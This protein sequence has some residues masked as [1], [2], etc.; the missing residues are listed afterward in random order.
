M[1]PKLAFALLLVCIFAWS[2]SLCAQVSFFQPPTFSGGGN[3][4]VADF[5]GDGKPDILTSDGTMNVGNGDG[6]FTL[7]TSI[8]SSPV[9]VLAV[10]DF[11]GDG[12]ADVLEQGTGTLLV[13][14]GK[15]DGTFQA[16][17]STASGAS[18][19]GVIV[20]DVN[21][22]GKPDVLGVFN[23]ALIVYLGKGDG[24]FASGV[25]Y[26][27]GVTTSGAAITTVLG[28]FNGDGK[29][30]A[31][32]LIEGTVGVGA[33]PGLVLL[34]NGDGTFRSPVTSTGVFDPGEVVT[35]DFNGDGKL[36]LVI[37]NTNSDCNGTTCLDPAGIYLSLGNGDGTFQAPTQTSF[38]DGAFAVADVNGDGNLDVILN[39]AWSFAQ[40]FLGNG[41]GTFS[42]DSDYVL[43]MPSPFSNAP[44]TATVVADFNLDGK[45]DI[46]AGG[47][48]QLG[49]GD[50]TFRGIPLGVVS[51]PLTSM[52]VGDFA[53]NGHPGVA[54]LPQPKNGISNSL[55]I[56]ANN[57]AGTLTLAH[58]YP[59]QDSA[60]A[61]VTADFNGD[62]N[63]DL[64][65]T[66]FDPNT[67]NWSYT[68]LL[69]NG[70]GSFQLPAYYPQNVSGG[71]V[72]VVGDFNRDGKPDL[73]VL[74][75]Q[76]VAVL[77]G[78]GDGTFAAPVLYFDNGSSALVMADFN[79]DGK[80]DLAVTG[81][82][83]FG[84]GDG[85][86]QAAV[87]PTSLNG[88]IP[89]LTADFN[90][91][92][93]PDLL[94]NSQIALGNGDGTFNLLPPLSNPS[95]I[96]GDV[97][98]D[99]ILDLIGNIT[100]SGSHP[101]AGEVQLGL[102]NGSF[103]AVIPILSQ[104]N[105][106]P[107]GYL[108]DMNGDGKPDLV[109]VPATGAGVISSVAGVAV[110]LNTTAA[111]GRPDFSIA[112][113]SGSQTSQSV[114]AGQTAN[115]SLSFSAAGSFSGTVNLTCSVT[116]AASQ[117]P[118]CSLSSSSV[119]LP[120]TGPQTVTVKIGTTASVTG[121]TAPVMQLPFGSKP[122]FWISI[123]FGLTC[124]S[125]RKHRRW[126]L[127]ATPVIVLAVLTLGS[128]GG[129]GSSSHSGSSGTPAG[130]YTA[131][132]TATSGSLSHAQAFQ[133]TVQ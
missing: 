103:G 23:N 70:D 115:F 25:P 50:G 106:V 38:P 9:P 88:F 68:V 104:G 35:G 82:L 73:A 90:N 86:F 15:G 26:S 58:A 93:K 131:T 74:A 112:P 108:A 3:V 91:D 34:G 96:V 132:V 109:F 92:G 76:S 71:G 75:G 13:L 119:Q 14:L 36:D 46:A 24:T 94:S 124:L 97:N 44:S 116:P 47:A 118:T 128:C 56:L 57:G 101:Y 102:G 110:L 122:L 111:F 43:N 11:N 113:A 99:G 87:F 12:K 5:N 114:T 30:D 31:A 37:G 78:N 123:I 48:V 65:V 85:T 52:A 59:L 64:V 107:G 40:I 126:G 1:T 66:G 28:D 100:D 32:V 95:T 130:T 20:G 8:S 127:A 18:L 16:P 61:I 117:G 17:V 22:D 84:N 67:T 129:S 45:M 133:I 60:L 54:I 81:G 79:N 19:A 83:L 2:L 53:K 51:N 39:N 120:G 33:G 7:G 105:I 69:G 10:V 29:T 27:L 80:L 72:S 41:D 6:T 62:G 49:N 98:G 42:N 89:L 4:F 55:S 21:G 125:F 77:I 63:L 121:M